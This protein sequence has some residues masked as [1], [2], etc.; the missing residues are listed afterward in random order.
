MI[1][2]IF[3]SH[4][5]PINMQNGFDIVIPLDSFASEDSFGSKLSA[6]TKQSKQKQ[7]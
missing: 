2:I 7:Y 4:L 5:V 6:K 3:F 1:L